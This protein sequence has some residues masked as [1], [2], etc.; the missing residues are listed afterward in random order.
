MPSNNN[1][2]GRNMSQHNKYNYKN[3]NNKD[4]ANYQICRLIELLDKK[5]YEDNIKKKKLKLSILL[6]L[7]SIK[8]LI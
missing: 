1:T 5:Q 6:I 7:K 2:N 3:K 8:Y 4:A